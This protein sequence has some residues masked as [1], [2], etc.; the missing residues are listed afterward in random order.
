M[1]KILIILFVTIPVIILPNL[2]SALFKSFFYKFF[3]NDKKS[4][5]YFKRLSGIVNSMIGKPSWYRPS[6]D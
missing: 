6:L 5:I 3:K 2:F 1:K 4:E